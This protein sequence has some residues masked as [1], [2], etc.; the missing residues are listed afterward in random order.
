MADFKNKIKELKE[1]KILGIILKVIKV[2]FAIMMVTFIL[3]VLL[4]RVS[5]N[6]VSLFNLRIFT[7]VSG[8]MEPKYKIG[9]VLISM[10]TKPEDIKVGDTI[11]YIGER[12]TVAGKIITHQVESIDK[13][14]NNKYVFHTKGLANDISD[15][16]P[17][18]EDQVYGVVIYKV[19][20]LSLVY[21]V[22][23]TTWGLFVFV[24]IPLL[25]I[26]GSEMIEIMLEKEEERRAKLK[27]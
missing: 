21:K 12:G 13:D 8:S 26:V 25:Y 5:N 17:V 20:L 2:C 18:T 16:Y 19:F 14:L 23:G 7:V 24:V 27:H 6:R 22:I 1:N 4:Q 10:E 3:M 11:S 9:D 15:I